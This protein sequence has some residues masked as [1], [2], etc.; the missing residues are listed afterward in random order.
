MIYDSIIL[1]QRRAV[2]LLHESCLTVLVG[3]FI[4]HHDR[5]I[6]LFLLIMDTIDIMLHQFEKLYRTVGI[7]NI[8]TLH[9][10]LHD[11]LVGFL[12]INTVRNFIF[13]VV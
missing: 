1:I 7:R 2:L 8:L 3:C 5:L 11:R 6:S 4:I 10:L 13:N 12:Y 9:Q